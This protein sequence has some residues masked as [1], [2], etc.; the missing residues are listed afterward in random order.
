[1]NCELQELRLFSFDD[2]SFS[3]EL[4]SQRVLNKARIPEL[5]KYILENRDSYIFSALTVSVSAVPEFDPIDKNSSYGR[6]IGTIR[7][8][9]T[10]RM[11]IN[12]GQHRKAAI[13]EAINENPELERDHISVILF[14]D[15]G[16]ENTQQMF[17]DL[18]KHA[19]KPSKSIGILYDHRDEFSKLTKKIINDIEYFKDYTDLEKTTIS[20]RSN[21]I[22]TLSGLYNATSALLNKNNKIKKVKKRKRNSQLIFGRTFRFKWRIGIMYF[23]K[24]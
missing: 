21:K 7:I 8:P 9:T 20:N 17:S 15:K 22:F 14:V 18:N 16:L 11:I 2:A 4:R 24:E 12:D 6:D 19:V 10:A 1:M 13:E 23:N 3:P 5:K